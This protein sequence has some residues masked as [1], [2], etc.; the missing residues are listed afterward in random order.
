[1]RIVFCFLSVVVITVFSSFS[2]YAQQTNPTPDVAKKQSPLPSVEVIAVD[3]RIK[4]LNAP[5]GSRLE[6]YSVVGIKV[7]EIEMK[8]TSGE[9]VVQIAKGYYIVRIGET[10][11][12]VAIR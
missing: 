5:V 10:V 6:I 2:S 11:R 4:V 3:N 9:Y 7:V 12:K 8:Q 1:M